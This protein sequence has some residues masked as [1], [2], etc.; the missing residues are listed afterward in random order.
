MS[1]YYRK[2][3][4]GKCIPLREKGGPKEPILPGRQNLGKY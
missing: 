4:V 1:I 2:I 3:V